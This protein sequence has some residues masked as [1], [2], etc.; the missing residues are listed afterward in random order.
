MK[1]EQLCDHNSYYKIVIPLP[2]KVHIDK[3]IKVTLLVSTQPT[4]L[5]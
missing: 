2:T 3:N 1:M 4:F 5:Y